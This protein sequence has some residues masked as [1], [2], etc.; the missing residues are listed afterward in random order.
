MRPLRWLFLASSFVAC[1]ER[2]GGPGPALES[3]DLR[4]LGIDG[5]ALTDLSA[6][7]QLA[8]GTL[9]L[10]LES[11][12]I[13]VLS[14]S[15]SSEISIN[16]YPCGAAT[17]T[18]TRSVVVEEASAGDQIFVVDYLGGIF[19]TGRSGT[20][21]LDVD[22]GGDSGDSLRIRGQLTNDDMV[23]GTD[24]ITVNTDSN[25]DIVYAGVSSV[26]ISLGPGN[27]HF[28]AAGSPTSG[29]ALTSSVTVYGDEGNDTLR[30]GDGDDLLYGGAGND[31]FD[32]GDSADGA[33]D[34]SGGG[35]LDTVS[36][37]RR[38]SSVAVT[39]DDVA[40]DG[41]PSEGDNV[42][43][44]IEVV[45]GGLGD[46]TLT[47]GAGA[48]TLNGGP[49]A[50]TID[51]GLGDDV[52]NGGPGDDVFDCGTS[53]DGADVISGGL[54]VDTAD[55]S[56]RTATLAI[57]LNN[58]AGDGEEDEGDNV[59]SDVEN[60]YGGSVRDT[61]VGSSSDNVLEG[62]DGDDEIHGGGGH[63]TIRGGDGDDA[64]YGD[65][66]NDTF[67]EDD[68][69][70]GADAIS[71]G[72]GIDTVSYEARTATLSVTLDGVADDGET[73]EGDDLSATDVEDIYGGDGPDTIVGNAL[74][75][76]IWGGAGDDDISGDAGADVL[77]GGL[78]DD[79][80]HGGD[81]DD[82]LDGE[83]GT[84]L[85]FCGGGDGDV[86]T[87]PIDSSP[88]ASCELAP[89]GFCA[90]S[91]SATASSDATLRGN[92]GGGTRYDD[93]CPAG[94]A[95]IGFDAD[96]GASFDGITAVCGSVDLSCV[97]GGIDLD[98]SAGTTL[99]HR[100]GNNN[101]ASSRCPA[102]QLVVGMDV[103]WGGLIDNVRVR[104]API[105]V[106][107]EGIAVG[108]ASAQSWVNGAAGSPGASDCAAGEVARGMVIRA[109]N[110]LDAIGLKCG[111][112]EAH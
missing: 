20:P 41:A 86:V 40:D 9:T 21:G 8:S 69:S 108:A 23:L 90:A 104:C 88:T 28:S 36:Y 67:D 65:A 93:L 80:L 2:T 105:T 58:N 74:G 78:G 38:T 37:A 60:V 107:D 4:E 73:S 47:G 46:D 109:G 111:L 94:E 35:G 17:M 32:C 62:R 87:D 95:L 64:L 7:C 11:G 3:P 96:L 72:A 26:Y 13:A 103:G 53:T 57:S 82:I 10:S 81:G 24:G 76:K 63:D 112:P 84:D 12:D 61:I 22:L 110:S 27:D 31:T 75:N 101:P 50:D 1:S 48:E 83:G 16:G 51:G 79:T 15:A 43:T 92:V 6:Q 100:G 19:A 91:Y 49:G 18:N 42:S 55:Y 77:S 102:G 70:N 30:G 89:Q 106:D 66:G 34:M 85:M 29:G 14:R 97:A 71:G 33:D 25:L 68:H 5:A 44:D 52:L 39:V 45:T 99:S 59:K 56:G 54:G 98:V